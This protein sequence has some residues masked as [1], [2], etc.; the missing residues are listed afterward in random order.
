[1]Q[2]VV[3]WF[4]EVEGWCWERCVHC[5]G[6]GLVSDY[7]RGCD[8][9]GAKECNGCRGTGVQWRTPRGRYVLYPGGPFC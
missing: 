7:G 2:T 4:R 6:H 3:E 9:Y 8:F 1:M 5:G